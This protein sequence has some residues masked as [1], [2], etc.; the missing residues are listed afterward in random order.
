VGLV[1]LEKLIRV[2]IRVLIVET[3]DSAYVNQIWAHVIHKGASIDVS[4]ERPV[5]SMLN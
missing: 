3:Y 2:D 4:W 1:L 5:Y